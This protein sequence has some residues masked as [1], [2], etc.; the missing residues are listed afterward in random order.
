MSHLPQTDL[1]SATELFAQR[2][3]RSLRTPSSDTWALVAPETLR[4]SDAPPCVD[5]VDADDADHADD[6][7]P[8]AG[9]RAKAENSSTMR[10]ISPTWRTIVSV[11]WLKTALSSSAICLP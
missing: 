8:A 7:G 1:P 6:A 10:P 9:M 3:L 2:I 4:L 11:H 5:G